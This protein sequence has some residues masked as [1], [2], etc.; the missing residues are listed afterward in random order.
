M[1]GFGEIAV[2]HSIDNY[3]EARFLEGFLKWIGVAFFDYTYN[4]V[5]DEFN[6]YLENS[7]E[8]FDVV[9]YIND[10]NDKYISRFGCLSKANIKLNFTLSDNSDIDKE[11]CRNIWKIIVDSVY[12][13]NTYQEQGA[14]IEIRPISVN[15][16]KDNAFA[17]NDKDSCVQIFE[18]LAEIYVEN[19]L[20]KEIGDGKIYLM[21]ECEMKQ[22]GQMAI[23][24][25]IKLWETVLD[26]L[27]K[28]SI[29][30]DYVCFDNFYYAKIYC[31]KEIHILRCVTEKWVYTNEMRRKFQE[32]ELDIEN[33]PK[34]GVKYSNMS[35]GLIFD[36]YAMN[37]ELYN[38][39]INYQSRLIKKCKTNACKSEALH[40]LNRFYKNTDRGGRTEHLL[41]EVV[42]LNPLNFKAGFSLAMSYMNCRAYLKAKE[43]ILNVLYVLQLEGDSQEELLDNLEKLPKTE[44]EYVWRC[45]GSLKIIEKNTYNDES[46]KNYYIAMQEKTKKVLESKKAVDG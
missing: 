30:K 16:R 4:D 35:L 11:L 13:S 24:A 26:E 43:W 19:N 27:D 12:S 25:R 32:I 20:F 15:V 46:A 8:K 22:D 45:Y 9:I 29:N 40:K 39:G 23:E 41:E 28:V 14:D 5:H 10:E 1:K 2:I 7:G 42:K 31:K 6:Q 33:L 17:K 44:L 36:I 34:D 37:P 21:N 38:G 3:D 18:K